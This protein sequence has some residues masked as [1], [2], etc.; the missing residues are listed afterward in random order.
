MAIFN[1]YVTNYQRVS[2]RKEPYF[3][4]P[5]TNHFFTQGGFGGSYFTSLSYAPC[6]LT[7]ATTVRGLGFIVRTQAIALWNTW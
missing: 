1:S 5:Q 4:R 7:T 6:N 2:V 3:Y